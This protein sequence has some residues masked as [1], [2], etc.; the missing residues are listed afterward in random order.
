MNNL[1]IITG[2]GAS[3]DVADRYVINVRKDYQ[4]PL[5]NSLFT[6]GDNQD[7][8]WVRDCLTANPVAAQVGI[9]WKPSGK[10]LENYL[11]DL[12]N[13][14]DIPTLQRQYFAVPIYLHDLFSR[15]S[16]TFIETAKSGVPSNYVSLINAIVQST[17]ANIIWL[18]LNYDLFADNAIG[19]VTNNPLRNF[20]DYMNIKTKEGKEIKYTK[21]HGSVNWYRVNKNSIPWH[22][23]RMGEISSDFAAYLSEGIYTQDAA[24]KA[25][26]T[27][28]DVQL[29]PALLA[30]VGKYDYVY[31]D[32]INTIQPELEHVSAV[33]C[34]GFSAF[35]N[36]ILNLLKSIPP[37]DNLKIVNGKLDS[38]EEVYRRINNYCPNL[39]NK[40]RLNNIQHLPYIFDGGFTSFVQREMLNWLGIRRI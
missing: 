13:M 29:Y 24:H 19:Y 22:V 17:Y 30:P 4:P 37:I 1:L 8:K 35:D 32:H 3:F 9:D 7:I 25:G 14:K 27:N 10:P 12:Q 2:A 26:Y 6:S 5:T 28:V 21:P 16:H 38:G 20:S 33:L 34:I 15:I 23:I 18:N 40:I 36:D 39:F 11:S 31:N